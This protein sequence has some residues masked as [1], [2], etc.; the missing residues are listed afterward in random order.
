MPN[1]N[2]QHYASD[3]DEIVVFARNDDQ[4]SADLGENIENKISYLAKI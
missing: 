3:R 4:A 2:R 1:Q